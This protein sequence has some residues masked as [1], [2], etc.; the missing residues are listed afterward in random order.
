MPYLPPLPV[1]VVPAA[2]DE[3]LIDDGD[4]AAAAPE[5]VDE[6]LKFSLKE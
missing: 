4:V 1:S 2:V 3:L 5:V 6:I